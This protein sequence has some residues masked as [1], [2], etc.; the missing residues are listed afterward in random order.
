MQL[1]KSRSQFD[2]DVGDAFRQFQ[3][4]NL[5]R[6]YLDFE[7]SSKEYKGLIKDFE[8]ETARQYD[9]MAA[10]PT[11]QRKESVARPDLSTARDKLNLI[12]GN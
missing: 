3:E 10:L 7:R 2:I 1:L 11:R 6:S 4:K 12:L 9:T 5:G 8:K